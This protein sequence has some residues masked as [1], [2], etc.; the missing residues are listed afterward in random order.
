[1]N[2]L[3]LQITSDQLSDMQDFLRDQIRG[4]PSTL[5]TLKISEH[6]ELH[7]V[8]PPGTPR[9]GPLDLSYT[10]YLIEPMDN[11]SPFSPIKHTAI[12]KGHQLGF[13]LMA[14]CVL[15]YFMDHDPADILFISATQD[16]LERWASRRLEP[17]IN[18]YK[19][20][21]HVYAQYASK[22]SKRTGDKTYSKEYHGCRLDM[23]S[24]QAA[25]A[26]R[27]TDKRIV[28]R[29]E[30]DGAPRLLKTGEGDW[31]D[32][33]AGRIDFWGARG[34]ILDF[35]TPTLYNA[36]AIHDAFIIGDQRFYFVPCVKCGEMQMLETERL[37][38]IIV[39]GILKDVSY[40][41]SSKHEC[42]LKNHNK[43]EMLAQGGWRPTATSIDPYYRSYQIGTLYAP[44]GAAT[45][46]SIYKKRE[47][48]KE[49][50]GGMRSFKNLEEGWPYREEGSRPKLENVIGLRGNYRK[51]TVPDGVIF[52]T[53]A[54][55][56][57]R[58]R[59]DN[60]D[61]PARLE[62]EIL[63]HGDKYRTWS[64][65]YKVFKGA[66]SD[67]YDGAWEMLYKWVMEE[68]G[69]F[70]QRRDGKEF[71][72]M[73][74]LIDSGD[75]KHYQE[76]YNFC[77]GIPGL[78]PLKGSKDLMKIDK[79]KG[80]QMTK[81]IFKRYYE[82][83]I[84]ATTKLYSIVSVL[85]R[86]E[87]YR[88]L[89]RTYQVFKEPNPETKSGFCGFPSDYSDEYFKQLTAPEKKRDGSFDKHD[90]PSEAHDV[91]IYNMCAGDIW[92]DAR[93]KERHEE[94]RKLNANPNSLKNFDKKIALIEMQLD[95]DDVTDEQIQ[96]YNSVISNMG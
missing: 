81:D 27:A 35:S 12:M 60:P 22:N 86:T 88:R 5:P 26:L 23:A 2:E 95:N 32:V 71:Q 73:I 44:V 57:Q 63:G 93:V 52:L 54:V 28:I 10:P 18:S 6:A 61:K 66:I 1:M 43:T 55:D 62:M 30:I 29:D 53:A 64:V 11:M 76:V 19:L 50:I 4:I 20:R 91:R 84:S 56:V 3:K 72:V 8:M 78:Y 24:A 77:E 58:G 92:L 80:D 38:P 82:T 67:P 69:L 36:S 75:G 33:S 37:H 87:L 16:L 9:P 83:D 13:T 85:Y 70:Y 41:C 17:A 14:E 79:S 7:R 25:A 31:L 96:I 49:K 45:W 15:C 46:L 90:R 21:E 59:A 39:N 42:E 40:I 48:A 65:D 89:D 74:G 51:G 47:A 34:K 68:D 94:L